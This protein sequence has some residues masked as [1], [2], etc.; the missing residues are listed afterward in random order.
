[1]VGSKAVEIEFLEW[2]EQENI[3]KEVVEKI[4]LMPVDVFEEYA[5]RFC[6]DTGNGGAVK[7]RLVKSFKRSDPGNLLNEK[8]NPPAML[9]RIE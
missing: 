7:R 8:S 3:G 1:M 6:E 4:D 5:F 9:G 2:I